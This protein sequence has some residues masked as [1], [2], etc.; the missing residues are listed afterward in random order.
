[1]DGNVRWAI[2][3]RNRLLERY[4]RH[5]T[6]ASW[7]K[8]GYKEITRPCSLIRSNKV[9]YFASL[10]QDL[11]DSKISP[12]TCWELLSLYRQKMRVALPTLIEG[13][14]IISDGRAKAELL[15]DYFNSQLQFFLTNSSISVHYFLV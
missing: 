11:G 7:K 14:N 9:K 5:K 10:Y 6:A 1:M 13:Q 4:S 2:R 15:N 12:K 8:I 3:K